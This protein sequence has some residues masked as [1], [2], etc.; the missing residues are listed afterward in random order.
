MCLGHH[1]CRATALIY[2]GERVFDLDRDHIRTLMYLMLS[3]ASHLTTFLTRTRAL[4]LGR[5]SSPVV[6][7]LQIV[8]NPSA[9]NR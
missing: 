3:V 8:S 9:L 5:S 1:S 4:L 7:R 6:A 2:L